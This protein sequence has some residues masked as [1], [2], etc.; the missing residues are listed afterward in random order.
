MVSAWRRRLLTA[1]GCRLLVGV[2]SIA[3]C[4]DRLLCTYAIAINDAPPFTPGVIR[5][6]PVR[7]TEM[8]V[9]EGGRGGEAPSPPSLPPAAGLCAC[10]DRPPGVAGFQR[11]AC[12]AKARDQRARG[13]SR[14]RV[15]GG[16]G[17]VCAP[18]AVRPLQKPGAAPL[19]PHRKTHSWTQYAGQRFPIGVPATPAEPPGRRGVPVASGAVAREPVVSGAPDNRGRR[20]PEEV[21]GEL[22]CRKMRVVQA[23]PQRQS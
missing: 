23:C 19:V 14:G 7:D 18:T 6:W 9:Q 16:R 20:L 5:P 15:V 21:A 13:A 3:L 22:R 4:A 8:H 12:T 10:R 17:V 2:L 11:T 1:R